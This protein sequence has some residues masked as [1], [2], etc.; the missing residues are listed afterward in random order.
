MLRDAGVN[1]ALDLLMGPGASSGFALWADDAGFRVDTVQLPR[2]GEAFEPAGTASDL[3]L[4]ER[5]PADSLLLVNG[6]DLGSSLSFR[7]IEQLLV[8][9]SG[10]LSGATEAMPE[11]TQDTID[12]QFEAFVPLLGF[13][14]QTDFIQQL[15]GEFGF[16]VTGVDP[17]DQANVSALLTSEVGDPVVVADA[18]S[19]IGTLIQAASEGQAELSTITIGDASVSQIAVV[20]D[21][22][23]INVQYGVIGDEFA[24]GR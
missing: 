7:L 19:G 20:A 16:A 3:M 13:N 2:A 18:L 17:M 15:Q 1:L 6:F 4:A 9:G 12:S 5:L 14:L 21:G 24:I 10:T 8:L 22:S 23:E 11:M